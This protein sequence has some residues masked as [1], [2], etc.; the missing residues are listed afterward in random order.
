VILWGNYL[1]GA[2]SVVFNGT[3]ATSFRAT[4]VRSVQ[5]TVPPGATTGPVTITTA[6]GSYT[7]TNSF[8]VQ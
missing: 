1:L 4:S 6:K 3:P 5:V 8:T 2:K 7:T